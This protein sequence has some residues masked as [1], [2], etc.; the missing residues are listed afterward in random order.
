[1]DMAPPQSTKDI[2]RRTGR[3]AALNR[4]ISRSVE[5]SLPFLK[6]LRGAKD[7]TWGIEQAAA[8]KS[9]KKYLS[10]LAT[11]TSPDPGLPMLLYITASP[12]AVSAALVQEKTRQGK[13]SHMDLRDKVGC[14]SYMCQRRQHI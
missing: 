6:T 3:L 7:F 9:L 8:F 13:M 11:L 14:I 12:S 2:Q 1:M 5:R 10:D 4:F